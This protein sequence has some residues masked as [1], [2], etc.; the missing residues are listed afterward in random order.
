MGFV[1][2]TQGC[3]K[4]AYSHEFFLRGKYFLARK[5]HRTR[6]KGTFVKGAANPAAEPNFYAMPLVNATA[7]CR[8]T[9]AAVRAERSLI[10]K[11]GACAT[12]ENTFSHRNRNAAFSFLDKEKDSSDIAVSE[13]IFNAMKFLQAVFS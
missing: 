1:K 13:N 8:K 3:D 7:F 2:I 6:V 12:I 5:I 11:D 9:S 4:G 10:G